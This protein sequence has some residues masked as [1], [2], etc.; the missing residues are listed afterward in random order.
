VISFST[1]WSEN[2]WWKLAPKCSPLLSRDF[3]DPCFEDCILNPILR[4]V[5]A[6]T[7]IFQS[8]L[9]DCQLLQ[10]FN[11]RANLVVPIERGSALGL[12][13]AHQCTAPRQWS[14]FEVELLQQ[15]ADQVGVAQAELL[16][17]LRQ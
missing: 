14:T 9:Q 2:L 6:I 5:S 7:D 10:Q 8:K 12:L 4:D 1:S 3:K 11:V 15:L 13:I 17:A 16:E